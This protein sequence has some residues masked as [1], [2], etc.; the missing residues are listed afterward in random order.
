[1]WELKLAQL[2]KRNSPKAHA[3]WTPEETFSW[4]VLAHAPEVRVCVLYG[5]GGKITRLGK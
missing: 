5:L 4:L 1:M 3:S 2:T